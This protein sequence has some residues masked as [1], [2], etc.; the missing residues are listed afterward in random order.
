MHGCVYVM[1]Y[2]LYLMYCYV[3]LWC[4]Y[5]YVIYCFVHIPNIFKH[6]LDIS[7]YCQTPQ[8][9]NPSDISDP[10]YLASYFY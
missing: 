4:F 5:E 3:Y 9:Q 7:T 10:A 6:K 8:I 2:Y 1:H